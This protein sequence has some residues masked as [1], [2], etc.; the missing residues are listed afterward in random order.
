MYWVANRRG[1]PEKFVISMIDRG[2]P[3]KP[4]ARD[5]WGVGFWHDVRTLDDAE[6]R[7]F[8]ESSEYQLYMTGATT[9]G[10]Y[11]PRA[12]HRYIFRDGGPSECLVCVETSFDQMAE[13]FGGAEG[14]G[15]GPAGDPEAVEYL[16]WIAATLF[17]A[18][19]TTLSLTP[20]SPLQPLATLISGLVGW[21]T[22][23]DAQ[24]PRPPSEAQIA[25]RIEHAIDKSDSRERGV[26]IGATVEW[27]GRQFADSHAGAHGGS[28]DETAKDIAARLESSLDISDGSS[29]IN[30]MWFALDYP[31]VGKWVVEEVSAGAALLC[32][33]WHLHLGLTF[34]PELA[35]DPDYVVPA[36]AL[37]PYV[38]D[39]ARLQSGL[40]AIVGELNRLRRAEAARVRLLGLPEEVAFSMEMTRRYTGSLWTARDEALTRRHP[41]GSDFL[42]ESGFPL[43]GQ[44]YG[45]LTARP[46]SVSR[47]LA[48]LD[49][50]K[51]TFDQAVEQA[52]E[53]K[54]PQALL[55]V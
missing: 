46:D 24:Q 36:S 27:F 35:K 1:K 43:T 44:G 31:E 30:C 5:D 7:A 19:A 6:H 11:R 48:G 16:Q 29:F 17:R 2:D 38:Q 21:P 4:D 42:Q 49:D 8:Y 14:P 10:P 45:D 25:Q 34:V 26:T 22:G 28:P 9:F 13:H 18:T 32:K 20:L 47:A 37:E 54:W 33:L 15:P 41:D 53:Q 55:P 51:S 23:D 52:K 50:V 12:E 3:A 40:R 39:I